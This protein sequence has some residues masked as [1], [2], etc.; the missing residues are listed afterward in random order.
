MKLT[1]KLL[2]DS[3]PVTVTVEDGRIA[4]VARETD[5]TA[6]GGP[7]IWIAPGFHDLQVNGYGGRDFNAGSWGLEA[8]SADPVEEL[9]ALQRD[10]ARHGT[11]LFCPTVVTDAPEQMEANLR[12]IAAAV[13][14]NARFRTAV[15]G[16]HLEG[17]FISPEEGPRGAHPVEH[18]RLPD[19][20]LFDRFQDAAHGLIRMCTLAP[21]MPGA[22]GLIEYLVENGV[23]A[24]IG[25][26]GAGAASI[27]DAVAAGATVSTHIGNGCHASIPRH[28]S[29]IW[30]QL[31]CD[32][33]IATL[34]ADGHHIEPAEARVMVRA[35][36]PQAVAL[37][38]DAVRLA[39][40]PP[41]L[42]ADGR[43]EVKADGHIV[44][45][46][47]PYL[48][49]ASALLDT[50]IV[51][52][53]RWTDMDLA[54]AVACATETP[55]RALRMDRKGRIAVGCDADLTLFRVREDDLMEIVMTVVG[56]ERADG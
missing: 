26:T 4:H 40:M 8:S 31:A 22:L 20:D 43:F 18:I 2:D 42:Y 27:R 44:L 48:A 46:G 50:C 15:T 49:G 7:D 14:S 13:E 54:Q 6:L 9:A 30:E 36:R 10:L 24:A 35:K 47:T 39:G 45:T 53:W 38:S 52:A 3:L 12:R 21:E 41:G 34:I 55:A 37:I 16:V 19:A 56:G 32:E 51:N 23:V 17:P 29:Y 25:H 28:N 5:A 1:G 33:L 11:A